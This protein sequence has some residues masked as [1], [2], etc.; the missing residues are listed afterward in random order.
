V[1]VTIAL[2]WMVTLGLRFLVPALLPQVKAT[3]GI[4]NA[5]AGLAVTLL[6]A[7]YAL[8][9]FPAGLVA[10]R[11]GERTIL[12]LSLAV[13]ASSLAVLAGAPIFA[14]F[15]VGAAAFGVGSGLYG[16]ARGTALAK[17]FPRHSGAAFGITLA[18]GSLGSAA[19]PLGAGVVVETVGW[20]P[21]VA[22]TIPAFLGLAVLAWVALP[23]PI[24]D[25]S[26]PPNRERAAERSVAAAIRGVPAAIRNRNVLFAVLGITFYLFALQGLTAFLP[27]Y[28]V[29]QEGIGQ[30]LAAV[31]FALVFVGGGLTQLF[32]GVLADRYGTR[33]VLVGIAAVAAASLAAVPY[34][35]DL[36][37]W[38]GLAVLLGSRL[39]TAPVGNAYIIAALPDEA[40]GVSW[41]FLRTVFFLIGSTGSVVVGFM[42]DL[43]LFDEAFLVLAG[44]SVAS[45]LCFRALS[46]A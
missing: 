31:V 42:A 1:L 14:V 17:A 3:F 9:Q 24:D 5:T 13:S 28:L 15:L 35:D 25:R 44:V 19:I 36:L 27:T 23:D 46:P 45:L 8:T 6:W 39:G 16:P 12:A 22:V 20:R 4:D 18:A 7:F 32:A 38:A 26:D 29:D 33:P 40:Q 34:V 11:V 21:L 43:D 37:V 30:G 41:G 10:D 2:G